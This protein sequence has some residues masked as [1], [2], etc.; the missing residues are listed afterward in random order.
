MNRYK[1]RDFKDIEKVF[2]DTIKNIVKHKKRLINMLIEDKQ[3]AKRI[4]DVN[5]QIAIEFMFKLLDKNNCEF[6]FIDK[7]RLD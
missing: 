6:V 3:P 2:D 4:I 7:E 1:E 5:K